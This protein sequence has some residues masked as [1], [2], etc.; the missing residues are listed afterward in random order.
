[1][2]NQLIERL[3]MRCS[4]YLVAGFKACGIYPLDQE[5]VL[6]KMPTLNGHDRDNPVPVLVNLVPA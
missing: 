5:Q 3:G 6:K 1:M 2:L 4:L